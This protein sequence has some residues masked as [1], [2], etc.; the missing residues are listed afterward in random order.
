MI[1]PSL[2]ARSAPRL[3]EPF[4][5]RRSTAAADPILAGVTSSVL[6]CESVTDALFRG[7]H[8]RMALLRFRLAYIIVAVLRS[9]ALRHVVD[10]SL[11]HRRHRH[12]E[13][14]SSLHPGVNTVRPH[15]FGLRALRVDT[16]AP[17]TA[18][19]QSGTAPLV[20]RVQKTVRRTGAREV[21]RPFHFINAGTVG[22]SGTMVAVMTFR[23]E[24]GSERPLLLM[25]RPVVLGESGRPAG[26]VT[27][28]S[29]G[30]C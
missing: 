16:G 17:P 23:R 13:T 25:P 5:T 6:L 28:D 3:S 21:D 19:K 30:W 8:L 20:R 1:S 2:S 27:W 11:D 4:T 9:T 22:H 15:P 12:G 26:W 14:N 7:N 10:G 18:Q 24:G 29:Q